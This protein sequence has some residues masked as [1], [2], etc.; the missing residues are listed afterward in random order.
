MKDRLHGFD[1]DFT[2]PCNPLKIRVIRAYEIQTH[3]RNKN[4]QS[5]VDTPN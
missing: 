2:D 3:Q 5:Q 4:Q 1:T